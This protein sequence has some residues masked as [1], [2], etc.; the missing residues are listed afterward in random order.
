MNFASQGFLFLFFPLC[1][2]LYF[3]PIKSIKYKNLILLLFSIIFYYFNSKQYLLLLLASIIFNYLMAI[4]ISKGDRKKLYLFI[5]ILANISNLFF[6]KF[7]GFFNQTTG[8][9]PYV[10]PIGIS[11]Y[12]FQEISY[13]TDVYREVIKPQK[14]IFKYIL[15]IML[16]PQLIAGPIVRYDEVSKKL[17]NRKT[18]IDDFFDGLS[19]F[20][21]GLFKKCIIADS[22]VNYISYMLK[23]ISTFNTSILLSWLGALILMLQLY[24]DFSAYSDM[25]IGILKMFGFN[26]IKP[27]FNNPYRALSINDFWKRWN[28][29]LCNWF[30][31]YVLFPLC[32]SKIYK[33][34][35]K[36]FTKIFNKK[37]AL[38]IA[39]FFVLLIVW[40]LVGL[41]HGIGINYIYFALYYLIFLFLEKTIK[42]LS[43]PKILCRV[44]TITIIAVGTV[45]FYSYKDTSFLFLKDLFVN[46]SFIDSKFLLII[47][48][49]KIELFMSILF[50]FPV[51]DFLLKKEKKMFFKNILILILFVV[52]VFYIIVNSNVPFVYYNF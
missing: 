49:Y 20:T 16:F 33:I 5:G 42:F 34:I 7:L 36:L 35:I 32:N 15:Y 52:S 13:I 51:F 45:I 2:I 11:F 9:L 24:Y 12:T 29:S 22:F 3:L 6:Y 19:L 43:V 10:A 23:N 37:I 47:C 30:N 8:I 41:W 40:I 21:I 26:N 39:N 48:N 14:N 4:K 1:L 27:N 44:Y 31:D 28:I 46:K 25:A 18:T 38:R 17:N 50:L